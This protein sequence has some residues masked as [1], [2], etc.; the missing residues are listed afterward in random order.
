MYTDIHFIDTLY[1]NRVAVTSST[2]CCVFWPAFGCSWPSIVVAPHGG[3]EVPSL[4]WVPCV[5]EWF[6]YSPLLCILTSKH[7]LRTPLAGQN[8]FFNAKTTFWVILF[9]FVLRYFILKRLGFAQ[10]EKFWG[11]MHLISRPLNWGV[12]TVG[13]GVWLSP[14]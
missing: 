12:T 3:P 1:W 5:S 11:T 8:Q 6:A 13:L 4:F 10:I 14:L 9:Y 7:V 2:W